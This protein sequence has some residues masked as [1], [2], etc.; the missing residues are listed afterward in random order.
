M[1]VS[2]CDTIVEVVGWTL[3]RLKR[4]TLNALMVLVATALPSSVATAQD[5]SSW[6]RGSLPLRVPAPD[7]SFLNHKPAGLHGRVKA[8]GSELVFG[9]GSPA[10]FWGVNVQA[11][12]LFA[13]EPRSIPVHA[14][15]L[16]SLGVNL[17]RLHHHDSAWVT[18]NIFDPDSGTRRL[19]AESLDHLDQWIAALKAEGI[20]VWLD[21]HVGRLLTPQ[22][23]VDDFD[24][25]K[26]DKG[27]ADLRGFNY[28]SPSIQARMLE[29]QTAYLSHVN[30]YTGLSYAEDPAIMAVLITN[31][32][33]LTHHFGNRLLPD[34]EVPRHTEIYMQLANDFAA[35]Q[36]LSQRQVWRSWEH[37]PSKIFLNDLERRFND[38]MQESIRDTGY[39]GLVATTNSWGGMSLAGLPSL[40]TGDMID[41]HSYG[42][43]G[44]TTLDP[45][46]AADF[47][48]WMAAAQV[49]G[50]PLSISEWNLSPY[51][52]EDR[53]IAP[54]RVAVSGAHQ[55]WDA[56]MIYGYAQSALN[57]PFRPN[58][59]NFA[60]D[61]ALVA[62]MPAAALLFRR[63]DVQP[64]RA[65]YLIDLDPDALFGRPITPD[66]SVALRTTYEQGRL[67]IGMPATPELPWLEATKP[68]PDVIRIRDPD[69][70]LLPEGATE[71]TAD[72]GEFRRDFARGLFT[73]DTPRTQMAAGA[74]S[75]GPISLS[76]I[77]VLVDNP[78]AAIAVQSLDDL[79]LGQSRNILIS[80]T[81]R[82]VPLDD[83]SPTFLVEPLNGT[84]R[85]LGNRDL[86]LTTPG[87]R[88]GTLAEA[89][90]VT[91]GV[92][93]ID[94]ARVGGA[95]WL[96]LREAA[97]PGR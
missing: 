81:A 41:V 61:P 17:V 23:G 3:A 83:K 62:M 19:S 24:E 15:R 85:I 51:P 89:H 88:Q 16:A 12:A 90:D 50:L 68:D 30:R 48:S 45:A 75:G 82:A 93:V 14:K 38:L 70:S 95:N 73:V 54:L 40:T 94:L 32:N 46:E 44:Q 56:P 96:L 11:Y 31:E 64:A 5:V 18:P 9:D 84:L 35:E 43:P 78:M 65:T 72:T 60:Y 91:E 59:W 67:L 2:S 80:L 42:S 27:R 20:Y 55:G 21:L 10:R 6:Y 26:D 79:P 1:P 34:K 63:G 69:A 8:Q 29:F 71:V 36:G 92:H 25:I 33:D 76:A 39:D 97:Q 58:N 13:T 37:G 4:A 86:V 22:D 66:T 87:P 47:L 74:L 53:F 28:I 49:A 7:L 57:A 52:A 77:E